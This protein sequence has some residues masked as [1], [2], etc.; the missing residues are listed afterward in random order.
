MKAIERIHIVELVS[1]EVII[2]QN[3]KTE[4]GFV[5]L[6]SPIWL[7]SKGINLIFNEKDISY[8][9][10]SGNAELVSLYNSAWKEIKK[11]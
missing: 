5:Y 2:S 1:G 4:N 6:K 10:N 11:D 9:Y 3:M 7:H 8:D